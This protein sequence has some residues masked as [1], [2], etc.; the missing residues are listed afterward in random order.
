MGKVKGAVSD[1]AMDSCCGEEGGEARGEVDGE[2]RREKRWCAMLLSW[3]VILLRV[4]S[5]PLLGTSTEFELQGSESGSDGGDVE[6]R[7]CVVCA[8]DD[9]CRVALDREEKSILVA[10]AGE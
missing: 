2:G 7:E 4:D 6:E 10:S 5:A 3:A 1:S 8:E 9:H